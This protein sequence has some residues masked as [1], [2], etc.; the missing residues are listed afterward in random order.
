M[1]ID[2]YRD[3]SHH[4]D[5]KVVVAWYGDENS[6]DNIALECEDC[7]E[8]LMSFDKPV[9]KKKKNVSKKKN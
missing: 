1:S 5:H 6:P 9:K 3:L 7:C 4:I 2:S 8:V